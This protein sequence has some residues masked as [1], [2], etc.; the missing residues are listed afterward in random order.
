[1]SPSRRKRSVSRAF[2][3]LVAGLAACSADGT[4]VDDSAL[5]EQE[6]PAPTVPL[7]RLNAA[8][9]ENG[10]RVLDATLRAL[11]VADSE[12]DTAGSGTTIAIIDSGVDASIRPLRGRVDP[13]WDV[14]TETTVSSGSRPAWHSARVIGC[15]QA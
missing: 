15:R 1:M 6:A 9:R 3:L 4:R 14:V 11:N 13:G 2:L 7:R 8:E 10:L 5:R 12:F